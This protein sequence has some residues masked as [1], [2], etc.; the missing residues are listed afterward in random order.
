MAGEKT[1]AV[2]IRLNTLIQKHWYDSRANPS[3]DCGNAVDIES[4][5]A[6]KVI[7]RPTRFSG[8]KGAIREDYFVTIDTLVTWEICGRWRYRYSSSIIGILWYGC[9]RCSCYNISIGTF[10]SII[11]CHSFSRP[12]RETIFQRNEFRH[13]P[14]CW[15]WTKSL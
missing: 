14:L 13:P 7:F 12:L 4:L 9:G 6:R 10:V 3:G 2:R 5:S 1:A 8:E 11:L 15:A